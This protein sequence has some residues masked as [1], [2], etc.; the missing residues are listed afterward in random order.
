MQKKLLLIWLIATSCHQTN[1]QLNGSDLKVATAIG[2]SAGALNF[3][4]FKLIE[5]LLGLKPNSIPPKRQETICAAIGMVAVAQALI[6]L[7]G[8]YYH[9]VPFD[10]IYQ[11]PIWQIPANNATEFQAG[12]KTLYGFISD[13]NSTAQA[14]LEIMQQ[15][16]IKLKNECAA[17]LRKT[18]FNTLIYGLINWNNTSM[19]TKTIEAAEIM[20]ERIK[21]RTEWLKETFIS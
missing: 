8:S 9:H 16:T 10:Y 14:E 12:I 17:T 19:Q 11:H 4:T 5:K 13:P 21:T 6:Y 20:L 3:V 1:T 7:D 18:V 2:L 15:A